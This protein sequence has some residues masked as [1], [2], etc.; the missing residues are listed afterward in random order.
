[1]TP[2]KFGALTPGSGAHADRRR[3]KQMFGCIPGYSICAG[4]I[5]KDAIK[6]ARNSQ[7]GMFDM[8]QL[9]A[10]G[11]PIDA[12]RGHLLWITTTLRRRK[13]QRC[14]WHCSPDA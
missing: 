2:A 3:A 9:N 6:C 14:V 5:S 7:Y 10:W 4:P 11:W 13:M 1:M 8:A 12:R